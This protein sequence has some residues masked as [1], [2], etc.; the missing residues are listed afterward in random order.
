[1][2]RCVL[3]ERCRKHRD[4]KHIERK[5]RNIGN[6]LRVYFFEYGS[7]TLP[8]TDSGMDLDS[9]SCPMQK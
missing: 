2:A 7:F 4:H 1:M 3:P 8:E 5:G 6:F 9:D